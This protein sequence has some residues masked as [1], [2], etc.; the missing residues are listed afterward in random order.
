M[1]AT[2]SAFSR[3]FVFDPTTGAPLPGALVHTYIAGT[4]TDQT[5]WADAAKLS[6]HANPVVMDADGGKNI[7][8]DGA[9]KFRVERATGAKS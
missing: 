7:Y 1:A 4:T 2:P 9:Y 3:F 5:A 8:I 6:S